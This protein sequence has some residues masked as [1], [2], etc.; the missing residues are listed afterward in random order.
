MFSPTNT[1]CIRVKAVTLIRNLNAEV[2]MVSNLPRSKPYQLN[3]NEFR[4]CNV[5]S[6]ASYVPGSK[7]FLGRAVFPR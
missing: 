3:D 2:L 4:G 7:V 6:D 5:S 1:K